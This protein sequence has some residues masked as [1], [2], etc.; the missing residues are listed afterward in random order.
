[1]HGVCASDIR[2][3]AVT[4]RLIPQWYHCLVAMTLRLTED[5]TRA[6][7]ERAELEDRSMHEVVKSAIDAYLSNRSM[8][9]ADAI[10]SVVREDAELLD[11]L[12]R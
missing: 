4:P 10:S 2:G 7:R 12:S 11:R 3:T 6:L 1:M 8:R 9:L 5:E